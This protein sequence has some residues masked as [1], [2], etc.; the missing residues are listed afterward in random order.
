MKINVSIVLLALA[1]LAAPVVWHLSE[2]HLGG[3]D[4]VLEELWGEVR[5][6]RDLVEAQD[7][8]LDG[9]K[10]RVDGLEGRMSL[11]TIERAE[12]QS[13]SY[14]TEPAASDTLMDVFAQVVL[15][16]NRRNVNDGL[17]LA[18]SSFLKEFLG[19]PREEL[20]DTCEDME[21]ET[22]KE[23]LT[24]EDVGPIRVQLL[25]PAI[26]SLKQVFRNVQVF[27]PELYARIRSAGSL[28]VR[29]IRG[30][31][32]AASAHAYGLA[33]DLNIDGQLDTLGD[34]KTQLGLTILADFFKQE[35]WIW[36]AGFGREDSMHFE[37][38]REKL[39][40]W[41]RLGEI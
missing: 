39:E 22:L 38:S 16:A 36:G 8:R 10:N 29:R 18:G 7:Q 13:D 15:I 26:I 41:R 25:R 40:Q 5:A 11:A 21:N 19:L 28:C 2:K 23:M 14:A 34:G 12:Q 6:L 4:E 35:G 1:I 9:M 37:V 31:E 30:A 33:V 24:L 27:E 3:E 17:T 32:V 20:G